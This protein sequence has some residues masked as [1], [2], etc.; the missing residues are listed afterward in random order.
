MK[1]RSALSLGRRVGEEVQE[2]C[3]AEPRRLA[4]RD[5]HLVS[6]K[7][8]LGPVLSGM[9]KSTANYWE[10]SVCIFTAIFTFYE[11]IWYH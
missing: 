3:K 1:L 2:S 5:E 9:C 4:D 8:A 6:G 7:A 11:T 10:G